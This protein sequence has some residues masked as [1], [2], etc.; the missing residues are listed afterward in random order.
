MPQNA[1]T[2][3]ASSILGALAQPERLTM[4]SAIVLGEGIRLAD[5]QAQLGLARWDAERQL[6]RLV[7]ADLVI[8]RD[9]RLYPRSDSLREAL[10][11]LAAGTPQPPAGLPASMFDV[12]GKLS[13]MP[14]DPELR[15]RVLAW[16]ADKFDP[17]RRYAEQEVN[18]ELRSMYSDYVGLRRY[19][20]D[21]GLLERTKDGIAYWRP[22]R[23]PASRV[24]A[25]V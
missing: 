22:Q 11:E 6:S 7:A 9:E 10:A 1:T 16:A 14:R 21:Y 24:V 5:V 25:S 4:F 2:S 8:Q 20:V 3:R 23:D 17:G 19:L 18:T 15:S 13:A 12:S